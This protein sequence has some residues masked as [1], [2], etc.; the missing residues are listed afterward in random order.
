MTQANQYKK[1]P[2]ETRTRKTKR[3]EVRWAKDHLPRG[4][5]ESTSSTVKRLLKETADDEMAKTTYLSYVRGLNAEFQKLA[6]DQEEM[7]RSFRHLS[8]YA[9]VN[10][11]VDLLVAGKTKR[12]I[13]LKEFRKIAAWHRAEQ[14]ERPSQACPRDQAQAKPKPK[15]KPEPAKKVA[16]AKKRKPGLYQRLQNTGMAAS[17]A[18]SDCSEDEATRKLA[19]W[20]ASHQDT[21]NG[22]GLSC[23]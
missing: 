7:L 4:Q 5:A 16:Q 18:E 20:V 19:E 22:K 21:E 10:E 15:P 12:V 2:Q 3:E 1:Y 8:L 14:K 13:G 23:C 11:G 9:V 6:P 17:D